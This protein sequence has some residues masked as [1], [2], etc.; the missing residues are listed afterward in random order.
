MLGIALQVNSKLIEFKAT[1][2]IVA[3]L[4]EE[5]ATVELDNTTRECANQM[6]KDLT[7]LKADF[8]KFTK[9]IKEILKSQKA[10]TSGLGMSHK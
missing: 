9:K 6:D 5:L 7:G 2:T 1:Q 8:A 3:S 4:L 10:T